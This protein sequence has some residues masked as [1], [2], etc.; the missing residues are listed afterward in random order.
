MEFKTSS[1]SKIV[2]CNFYLEKMSEP[3]LKEC[4]DGVY[5]GKSKIYKTPFIFN[6]DTTINRNIAIL[7]MSG[8]GKSYFLKNFIIRSN[9]GRDSPILIVDWN[10][11]Y[12]EV[13][14]F[15]EGTVLTLGFNLKINILDLYDLHSIKN[16][17]NISE[18][19]SYSLKLNDEET[20]LLY[21]IILEISSSEPSN[22]LINL[23]SLICHLSERDD[24]KRAKLANKLLQL[25]DNPIFAESTTFP[26]RSL[27]DGVTSID[28]SMLK[29]DSQRN[30][31]SKYVL[32]I[33]VELMHSM[34]IDK[35][36]KNSERIIVLDET[37]RLIKNSEDV[38]ILFREGRKYGFSIIVATQLVND[39]NN[40]ILSNAASL[41]LFRLQSDNDYKLLVD[42]GV[43]SEKDKRQVM[44]LPVGSC[45]VSMALKENNGAI[46]K[47]FIERT[48][49]I[50]TTNYTLKGDNVQIRISHKV[51]FESTQNLFV[52]NEVKEKIVN[53]VMDN[54]N[55][56]EEVNFIQFLLN[57]KIERA[58]IIYYL[59]LLGLHDAQIVKNYDKALCISSE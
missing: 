7:G 10:N 20:Y 22:T 4:D 58:E 41:F 28:F 6:F 24:T 39:I 11:E 45:M 54:N 13:V 59:R 56:I 32:K 44:Q 49:G 8:S 47:F 14:R 38:G 36:Q 55:D 51:F 3:H 35:A 30:E 21:D 48:D 40:E 5:I 12:K 25:K 31:I 33:M 34:S 19:I 43:I 53:F 18:F 57:M 16:I 42:S 29:D 37:W 46:S 50:Q 26:I 52:S 2:S 17:R 9:L 27:L 15:L 1:N 23:N